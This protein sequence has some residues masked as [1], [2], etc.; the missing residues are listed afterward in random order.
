MPRVP[1]CNDGN[2]LIT[3]T[4]VKISTGIWPF[5]GVFGKF[6]FHNRLL[7]VVYEILGTTYLGTKSASHD[8]LTVQVWP[9]LYDEAKKAT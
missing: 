7:D 2:W 8:K 1:P 3:L 6:Y 4:W 9:E 5:T